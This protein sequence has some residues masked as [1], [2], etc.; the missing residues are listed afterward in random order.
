MKAHLPSRNAIGTNLANSASDM[1]Q[2]KQDGELINALVDMLKRPESDRAMDSARKPYG[3][4]AKTLEASDVKDQAAARARDKELKNADA[5]KK[6]METTVPNDDKQQ[7][8]RDQADNANA[9][10]AST[11]AA[12]VL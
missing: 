7:I 6:N 11:T 10:T 2:M 12:I 3:Q 9:R 5:I 1:S 8:S 4:H